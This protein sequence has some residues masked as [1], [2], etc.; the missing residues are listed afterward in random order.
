MIDQQNLKA[1]YV[2]SENAL[3]FRWT[4]FAL[5]GKNSPITGGELLDIFQDRIFAG[6]LG[7][8]EN[9]LFHFFTR[10]LLRGGSSDQGIENIG[11]C[12]SQR[13][14]T[15][16]LF[17]LTQEG[18]YLVFDDLH[19]VEDLLRLLKPAAS[20]LN[21]IKYSPDNYIV[22]LLL[23]SI[24][25]NAHQEERRDMLAVL[26]IPKHRLY[27]YLTQVM[28]LVSGVVK[29]AK[30]EYWSLDAAPVN[31]YFQVILQELQGEFQ[32]FSWWKKL[33]RKLWLL[34]YGVSI[35]EFR[36]P[37]MDTYI[38]AFRIDLLARETFVADG[39]WTPGI[40]LLDK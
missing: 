36:L 4:R 35:P 26:D 22:V 13:S 15:D 14:M 8:W 17:R 1:E 24:V 34:W 9:A 2:E 20:E 16:C 37:M 28:D 32:G 23:L 39:L 29:R 18:G 7:N 40:S 11:N 30:D 10:L 5:F 31:E 33:K 3:L 38:G 25:L 19:R 12:T 21:R 6:R 27:L